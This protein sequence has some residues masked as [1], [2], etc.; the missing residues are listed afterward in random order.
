M[1]DA[2]NRQSVVCCRHFQTDIAAILDKGMHVSGR[3]WPPGQETLHFAKTLG[4]Q[5]Y[6]LLCGFHALGRRDNIEASTERCHSLND[7]QI[8]RIDFDP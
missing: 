1:G 8:A 4:L 2:L 5:T 6:Q 7:G 3:H